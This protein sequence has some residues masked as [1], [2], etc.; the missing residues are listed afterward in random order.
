M[1]AVGPQPHH[2]KMSATDRQAPRSTVWPAAFQTS[3]SRCPHRRRASNDY[4]SALEDL[5]G[6]YVA[7]LASTGSIERWFGQLALLEHKQ[8]AHKL[9]EQVLDSSLKLRLQDIGGVRVDPFCPR[10]GRASEGL[11]A[12]LCGLFLGRACLVWGGP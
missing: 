3:G 12:F 1:M 10:L 4:Y 8:R 11:Y 6:T 5:L 9:C 2:L 7:R